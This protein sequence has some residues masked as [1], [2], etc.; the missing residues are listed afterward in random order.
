MAGKELLIKI[1]ENQCGNI[2]FVMNGGIDDFIEAY[3]NS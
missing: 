1:S 3:L 2:D